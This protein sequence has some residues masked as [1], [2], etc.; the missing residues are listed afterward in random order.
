LVLL[1]VPS[2]SVSQAASDN[3][4]Q[5][6]ILPFTQFTLDNGLTVLVREDHKL[7]IVSVT[8]IYRAGSRD[9]P[10]GREGMSHLIEHL[11]FYGSQHSPKN[12]LV[13]LKGLGITNTNGGTGPD[14]M[15]LIETAPV[16]ELDAVLWLESDRMGYLVPSLTQKTLNEQIQ[17]IRNEINV[18][19]DQPG[20]S[21]RYHI[22]AALFPPDHPYHH[23]P[24]G[25]PD[26]L[27]KITLSEARSFYETYYTPSNAAVVLAGDITPSEALDKVK[28]YFGGLPTG[29]R[30]AR[31]TTW[32]PLLGHDKRERL[33]DNA[34]PQLFL[35]WPTP[36]FAASDDS[37]LRLAGAILMDGKS[38]RVQRRL[39]AA[40][41][42]TSGLSWQ[43]DTRA[44]A[45][46]FKIS[47][48][49]Q[50]VDNF[51]TIEAVIRDAIA[52]LAT[53]G[54][55]VEELERAKRS[56]LLELRRLAQ[57]TADF[58]GQSDLLGSTWA[59]T[60]GDAGFL[61][62]SIK[63]MPHVTPADVAGAVQRWLNHPAFILDLE[64]TVAYRPTSADVDRSS[65]PPSTAFKA[66]KFPETHVTTLPNG[67]K[68]HHAQ[69]HGGPVA[70][71]SLI[72]HGG[73]SLDPNDKAGLA[74][75][76]S[77]LLTAGTRK[78]TEEQLTNALTQLDATLETTTDLDSIA[79]TLI[80]PKENMKAA[81]DIVGAAIVT[82]TFTAAAVDREKKKQMQELQNLS[83]TPALLS[84]ELVR[85]QLYGA[86]NPYG[87]EATGLGTT[88]GTSRITA[89]DVVD[90]HRRWFNPA[91]S[92]LVIVGDFD[93]T[94]A[95]AM[96][97]G[98][99]G[100][101]DSAGAKA[102]EVAVPA[103]VSAPG[104]YLVDRPG[105]EQADISV[106]TLVDSPSSPANP[107]DAVLIN[108]LGDNT[109]GR[110]FRDLRD[111]KQWAYWAH[112]YQ[113]GGRAG[114]M[115]LVRTQVQYAHSAD[116]IAAI[117]GH[118]EGIKGSKPISPDELRLAKDTLTL[119]LPLNWESD[120]GI[121]NAMSEAIRR[122]VPD[123]SLE[124]YV[125]D[126]RAVSS[127]QVEQAAQRILRPDA[128]IWVVIGDKSK[129]EPQLKKAGIGFKVLAAE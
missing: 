30:T 72:V 13:T 59:L 2:P 69:W 14:T 48:E 110:I 103:Q 112:G 79:V 53:Q 71:A 50:S 116:A 119:S 102:P 77:K 17:I 92:E 27:G 126:V 121:A 107:V 60:E 62:A 99:L 38:S 87:A 85:R 45:G 10:P 9:D 5:Q 49:A 109:A 73:A 20:G 94:Q 75:L 76:T 4:P 19:R 65:I 113:E 117:K 68:V 98:N 106:A 64:P 61:D 127:A 81:L 18:N 47:V 55:T 15:D 25:D 42:E 80:A 41:M 101:W 91:N 82:P 54:P 29:P 125:A 63:Q 123:G 6:P 97:G 40:G 58:N 86:G 16:S 39:A 21:V 108:I 124:K 56:N 105:M 52:E 11:L 44:M 22:A 67:L 35:T 120:D 111:L 118:L 83:S 89:A 33:F 122:G 100:R 12:Y 70:V 8:V 90:F 36:N 93:E 51:R 78:M 3:S 23:E 24:T 96:L 34:P 74:R 57:R 7:P 31:I 84:R 37:L 43:A 1:W 32:I 95:A 128:M 114:Q 28:R 26:D 46:L 66:A 88:T 104:V 115:L 129:I